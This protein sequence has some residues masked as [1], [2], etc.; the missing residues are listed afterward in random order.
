MTDVKPRRRYD[1]S[2]RQ[3][4]GWS[5]MNRRVH[6]QGV[7]GALTYFPS[8]CVVIDAAQDVQHEASTLDAVK[9]LLWSR[10]VAA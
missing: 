4:N 9:S 3:A 6:L 5:Q 1:S 2:G 10:Q 7:A 8:R